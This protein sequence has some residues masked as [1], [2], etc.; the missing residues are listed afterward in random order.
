MIFS[1]FYPLPEFHCGFMIAESKAKNKRF[2]VVKNNPCAEKTVCFF[3]T[4]TRTT[5]Q[6]DGALLKQTVIHPV[7]QR[8]QKVK[9][10]QL[11]G[12]AGYRQQDGGHGHVGR[13]RDG[14]KRVG[15]AE[16]KFAQIGKIPCTVLCHAA[17][18]ADAHQK[19]PLGPGEH[20][21]SFVQRCVILRRADLPQKVLQFAQS[22]RQGRFLIGA[23][24]LLELPFELRIAVAAHL[25]CRSAAPWWWKHALRPQAP[26]CA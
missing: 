5:V 18:I 9:S 6:Y 21:G 3:C 12:L 19:H 13:D 16:S 14:V 22:V 2:F 11:A 10:R 23:S 25:F 1:P 8:F 15:H 4:W 7:G 24:L 20:P 17:R 26:G